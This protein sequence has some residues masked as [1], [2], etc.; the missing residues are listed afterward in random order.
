M[1]RFLDE[2]NS[3]ADVKKLNIPELKILAEE[4]REFLVDNISRHGGH[5]SSNLGAVELTLALHK[6]F[7]FSSDKVVWDVGHQ[8]Y[9]H[10]IITGRRESF[11]T[12]RRKDGI[13]GFPKTEESETDAFNT[14]HSSTS[15]SAAL[16]FAKAFELEG[17]SARAVAII[18][19]GALTGGM[20]YEAL[21]HAGSSKTPLVVILNDNGMSISENV[22]GM[23]QHMRK[24]RS[25]SKYIGAKLTVANF[26]KSLP[27][28]GV[29]FIKLLH[30]TKRL[31]KKAL[32]QKQLFENMGFEY[33]GPIDGH[34]LEEL[35][36]VI[37]YAKGLNRPV[38]V[39]AVTQKGKGYAPS[40]ASP[41]LFH[42]IGGFDPETGEIKEAKD[43]TFSDIFGEEI[44]RCAREN[45][46]VVAVTAAMPL[47]TGL[48]E[49]AKEFPSRFF[50][51]GIAE[52][53]AVTFSAAMA[54]A[55]RVPV[56]AVY[57]TFLQ[58]GYDQIIHDAALQNLHMVFAIDRAGAAGSDG[59]THQGI[60]D[61][62]Y[63]SHIPNM[64]VM[65]PATTAE[66]REMLDIAVNKCTGPVAIRY[67]KGAGTDIEYNQPIAL[68]RG[69]IEKLGND[70][71]IVAI[72]SQ[73][74]EAIMASEILEGHG[75]SAS[76]VNARFLKPLDAEL[77]IN[78]A[79]GK[80]LVAVTEDNVAIGGLCD[81]VRRVLSVPVLEFGFPDKPL[82]HSSIKEQKAAAGID[83]AHIAERI[84]KTLEG[85]NRG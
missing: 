55:G 82:T 38:I 66:L 43:K 62:S 68:G 49:F 72:G 30:I 60:Y 36:T 35:I 74:K 26:L 57:S 28:V 75:I 67:P 31:F 83:A 40:E 2:V 18:G 51:V 16:G 50:D 11:D 27:V 22:G 71:L 42:G 78:Q 13:S 46:K 80:R 39:H 9:T 65:A 3:S 25:H 54:K 63:L 81:G 44:V 58:R 21:N 59:E 77:I 70:V 48:T 14:G 84:L 6:V 69:I 45:E 47:G 76:V 19:D 79:S 1:K 24:L 73:V 32:L 8:C 20:A 15:V 29:P 53:H 41:D 4:I 64:T 17:S 56:F 33:L 85:D 10:K 5:L 61:L 23:S 34:N 37:S 12:L 52:Q 7:E